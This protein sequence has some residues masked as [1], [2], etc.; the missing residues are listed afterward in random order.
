MSKS[1]YLK[2]ME[3][4]VLKKITCHEVKEQHLDMKKIYRYINNVYDPANDK[5]YIQFVKT[6]DDF[7]AQCRCDIKADKCSKCADEDHMQNGFCRCENRNIA[8]AKHLRSTGWSP[9]RK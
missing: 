2:Y 3:H 7:I 1:C 5:M 8:R 9:W 6:I 4:N